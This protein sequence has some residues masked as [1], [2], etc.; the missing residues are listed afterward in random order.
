MWH[1]GQKVRLCSIPTLKQKNL[2][3]MFGYEL[4]WIK[5]S[6]VWFESPIDVIGV[7]EICIWICWMSIHHTLCTKI[8]FDLVRL[9]YIEVRNWDLFWKW[10]DSKCGR[11]IDLHGKKHFRRQLKCR[12]LI[13]WWLCNSKFSNNGTKLNARDWSLVGKT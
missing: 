10:R 6:F 4:K 11:Q 1:T 2:F 7:I 9:H 3:S 5:K 8:A 13:S 12:I